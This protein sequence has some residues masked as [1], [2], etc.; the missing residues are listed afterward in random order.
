MQLPESLRQYKKTK[1][2]KKVYNN[3]ER[4]VKPRQMEEQKY[5]HQNHKRK[6]AKLKDKVV[7]KLQDSCRIPNRLDKKDISQ[8]T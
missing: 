7:I 5:Y 4:R 8:N 3:R 2:I 6:F 1:C